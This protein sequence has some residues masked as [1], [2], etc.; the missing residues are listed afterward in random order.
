MQLIS[1]SEDLRTFK[2]NPE[3][4][5]VIRGIEGHIGLVAVSGS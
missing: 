2:I 3:A 1:I 4:L 5:E